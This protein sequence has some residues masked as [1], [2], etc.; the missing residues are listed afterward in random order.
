MSRKR[1]SSSIMSSDDMN[2]LLS[3]EDKQAIAKRAE[4][5]VAKEAKQA[6]EDAYFEAE[7]ERQR[8]AMAPVDAQDREIV[9][10]L[11]P[12]SD[13]IMVDG[14]I[15]F[16]GQRYSVSAQL[17]PTLKEIMARGWEHE[18]EVGGANRDAYRPLSGAVLGPRGVT[19][20]SALRG[21]MHV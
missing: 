6:A 4:S 9:I 17:Y 11:A 15:F 8:K 19:T 1:L 13:R 20:R 12:H 3:P 7:L 16:H 21:G 2:A 14:V 5:V 10:D 18:Q